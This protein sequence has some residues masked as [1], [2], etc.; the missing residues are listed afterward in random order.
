MLSNGDNTGSTDVPRA[1]MRL[2]RAT[3]LRLRTSMNDRSRCQKTLQ[4]ISNDIGIFVSLNTLE[5]LE[6]GV[7]GGKIQSMAAS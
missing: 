2:H 7:P 1:L 5:V 6:T 3:G 4:K